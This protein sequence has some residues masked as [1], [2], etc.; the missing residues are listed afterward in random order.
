MARTPRRG[1]GSGKTTDE[2]KINNSVSA[3]DGKSG[4]ADEAPKPI[5]PKPLQPPKAGRTDLNAAQ[6]FERHQQK[7]PN[8]TPQLS[9]RQQAKLDAMKNPSPEPNSPAPRGMGMGSSYSPEEDPRNA[10]I[11]DDE[12]SALARQSVDATN[13]KGEQPEWAWMNETVQERFYDAIGKHQYADEKQ[14]YVRD[15][16]DQLTP[17]E[18]NS[19]SVEGETIQRG[20]YTYSGKDGKIVVE[21][22]LSSSTPGEDRKNMRLDGADIHNAISDRLAAAP[23]EPEVRW[24]VFYDRKDDEPLQFTDSSKSQHKAVEDMVHL[25]GVFIANSEKA[26]AARLRVFDLTEEEIKAERSLPPQEQPR[27]ERVYNEITGEQFSSLSIPPSATL[28]GREHMAVSE[29][30]EKA[31]EIYR[32]WQ[33]ASSGEVVDRSPEGLQKHADSMFEKGRDLRDIYSATGVKPEGADQTAWEKT[34]YVYGQPTALDRL[35]ELGKGGFAVSESG[36][37]YAMSG[38]GNSLLRFD[39]NGN[40]AG[41]KPVEDVQAFLREKRGVEFD[42]MQEAKEMHA[43]ELAEQ[44]L[45]DQQVADRKIAAGQNEESA[46]VAE[47]IFAREMEKEMGNVVGFDDDGDPIYE[48]ER[49][50]ENQDLSYEEERDLEFP[51]ALDENKFVENDEL[52]RDQFLAEEAEDRRQFGIPQDEAFSA[53]EEQQAALP[54]KEPAEIAPEV[55][56]TV[57]SEEPSVEVPQEQNKAVSLDAAQIPAE[58]NAEEVSKVEAKIDPQSVQTSEQE[59]SPQSMAPEVESV[60]PQSG[61]EQQSEEVVA[62]PEPEQSAEVTAQQLPEMKPEPPAEDENKLEPKLETAAAAETDADKK[63]E[64]LSKEN[65]EMKVEQTPSTFDRFVQE[66]NEK[67]AAQGQQMAPQQEATQSFEQKPAV[68][69]TEEPTQSPSTFETFA[70]QQNKKEAEEGQQAAPKKEE[71]Q[72]ADQK[73]AVEK[74]G[75]P[76]QSPSSFETFVANQN[77]KEAEAAQA[78]ISDEEERR[79]GPAMG[80]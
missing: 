58:V 23:S 14:G 45:E 72:S 61:D 49:Q 38:D 3:S 26:V 4:R 64:Q 28:S 13:G 8:A 74:A 21:S 73:P 53:N 70:E 34:D 50:E 62:K 16:A 57:E 56:A 7:Y 19:L 24:A 66:R 9:K 27:H 69:K 22:I 67:E 10:S 17:Q 39:I 79:R 25:Q 29:A 5:P 78:Q 48:K 20:G 55:A 71:A 60:A 47:Q 46:E 41:E 51:E 2:G 6:G 52:G 54:V 15:I 31:Q 30:F 65:E 80:Y 12:L 1:K 11:T 43:A 18:L 36:Y 44:K 37:T 76:T 42:A 68:D 40:P 59:I 75:E 77:Q 33:A 32:S 63:S 35:Q